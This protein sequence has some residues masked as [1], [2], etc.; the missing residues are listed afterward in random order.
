MEKADLTLKAVD[1][2]NDELGVFA[3]KILVRPAIDTVGSYFKIVQKPIDCINKLYNEIC[4]DATKEEFKQ[5]F[6]E[7]DDPRGLCTLRA[8]GFFIGR[9]TLSDYT[10]KENAILTLK[11][12]R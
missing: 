8:R 9:G 10:D 7:V 3:I 2:I 12:M 1:E 5:A 4:A 11:L 6:S